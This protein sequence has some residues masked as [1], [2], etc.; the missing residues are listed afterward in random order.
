[1][2]ARLFSMTCRRRLPLRHIYS[3]T[4][5]RRASS[6]LQRVYL[7][8]FDATKLQTFTSRSPKIAV[9]GPLKLARMCDGSHSSVMHVGTFAGRLWSLGNICSPVHSSDPENNPANLSDRDLSDVNKQPS[10]KPQA[11]RKLQDHR[12]VSRLWTRPSHIFSSFN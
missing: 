1:M 10:H 7:F 11:A 2:G 9:W 8:Q 5:S 6:S 4:H 3:S 12:I